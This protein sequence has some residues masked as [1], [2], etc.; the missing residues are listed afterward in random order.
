MNVFSNQSLVIGK[1]TFSLVLVAVLIALSISAEAQPTGKI[2]R[3]GFLS[4]ASASSMSVRV[5]S[6]RDGLRD[7]GYVEEKNI[8]IESRYA[9]GKRDRLSELA[10]ELVRIKVDVI[11]TGGSGATLAAKEA[12]NTVPI[13]MTQDGNPVATKVIASLAR[14]GGNVTG[15]STLAPE[16]GGKVL[17]LVKEILPKVSRVAALVDRTNPDNT[18]AFKDTELAAQS[19]GVRLQHLEVRNLK[20]I[21]LVFQAANKEHVD[22]VLIY[23]GAVVTSH[24]TQIG[25]LAI[26]NRMPIISMQSLNVALGRGLMSYG[27]NFGDLYRR[28]A[29]YVDKILKG[30]KPA[31]LPVEQPTKFELVINLK[32]AK[33]ISLSIPP[34][35][36]ARAD[37]VIR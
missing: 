6:F 27:P 14:P 4:L 28:A 13:V 33:Q 34:N 19:F 2:A 22:A 15:L 25:N 1:R 31:D 20:D 26:T 17:E 5:E 36:L 9:D 35:V 7:H 29:T 21:E 8:F 37:R 11:V 30:T 23:G 32:T 3:I 24:Q 16:M 12:T 18:Y 10:A